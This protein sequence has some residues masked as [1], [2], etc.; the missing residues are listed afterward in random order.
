MAI[1]TFKTFATALCLVAIPGAIAIAQSAREATATS[2]DFPLPPGWT[3][4]DMQACMTAGMPGEM[5]AELAKQA[6]VWKGENKMWM[7]PGMEPMTSPTTWNVKSIMDGRY[8][9]TE[10][11]GEMPGMGPFSGMGLAGYD[12]VAGKFVSTWIDS[13]SSGIMQGSGERSADGKTLTWKYAYMCP[14]NKKPAVMREVQ[15]FTSP[16][17]MTFEMHA[18]DPKSGKEYKCIHADLKRSR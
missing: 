2:D 1:R 6:G 17:A 3:Q 12:N 18:T 4:E 5:Q 14:I 11:A 15:T 16:D 10:V 13:H 8:I 7:A 9:Q